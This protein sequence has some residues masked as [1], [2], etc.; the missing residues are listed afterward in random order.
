M[1]DLNEFEK[2]VPNLFENRLRI[3]P[4]TD[5]QLQEVVDGTIDHAEIDLKE[6]EQ[7]IDLILD[8]LRNKDR[9]VEL[10]NLQIYLD[11]LY[12]NDLERIQREGKQRPVRFDMALVSSTKQIEDVLSDFLEEQLSQMEWDLKRERNID[13]PGLPMEIL[14]ALV[15]DDGTKR[16]LNVPDLKEELLRSEG[17]QTALSAEVIDFCI[18]RFN[19]LRIIRI[20]SED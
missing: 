19:Q 20:L 11:K 9:G 5:G 14:Y 1:S 13:K 15:T 8:N 2:L 3:E 17:G 6:P 12:R 4:M 10:A 18:N 16:S 7:C